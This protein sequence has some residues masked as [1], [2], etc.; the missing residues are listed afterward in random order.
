MLPVA[1]QRR[2]LGAD[3]ITSHRIAPRAFFTCSQLASTES[4]KPGTFA[5]LLVLARSAE[6]KELGSTARQARS[7]TLACTPTL[8]GGGAAG[9][10]HI[11]RQ[12][13]QEHFEH[14]RRGADCGPNRLKTVCWHT[15]CPSLRRVMASR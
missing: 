4:I 9:S 7:G 12:I 5:G 13:A 15:P 1:Q 6:C 2:Y 8:S 10:D 14:S 11:Q 3:D